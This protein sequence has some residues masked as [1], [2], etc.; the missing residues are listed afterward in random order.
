MTYMQILSWRT[1]MPANNICLLVST[2]S[3]SLPGSQQC[4]GQDWIMQEIL[5]HTINLSTELQVEHQKNSLT[6]L[7]TTIAALHGGQASRK[8]CRGGKKERKRVIK[9]PSNVSVGVEEEP[10]A[11]TS[12]MKR[13]KNWEPLMK[14][15]FEV[16]TR[17]Q[18]CGFQ[19][20]TRWMFGHVK[21]VKWQRLI[22]SP[23]S[24]SLISNWTAGW[25]HH[26]LITPG[27]AG[28]QNNQ[29]CLAADC[30]LPNGDMLTMFFWNS[31]FL[32]AG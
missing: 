24:S 25:N 19:M 13:I 28:R 2:V 11:L 18:S 20:G 27:A 21:V 8:I 9:I 22:G 30:S 4:S 17:T 10:I 31:T 1:P 29:W 5:S 26:P 7:K 16:Q 3:A 6:H 32:M 12:F 23:L 15:C 14:K